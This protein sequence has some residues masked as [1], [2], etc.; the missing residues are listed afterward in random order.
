MLD[1]RS[2]GHGLSIEHRSDELILHAFA[3]LDRTA[4]GVAVGTLLGLLLFSATI[5]VLSRGGRTDGI[6]LQLLSQY[7]PGYTVTIRGALLGLV[8]GFLSG[9]VFGWFVALLRN[10]ALRLYLW[11]LRKRSELSRLGDFLDR[12]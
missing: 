2:P 3:R 8:Y 6:D 1:E 4:F 9:F 5:F 7:Y 12:I 11:M 10:G